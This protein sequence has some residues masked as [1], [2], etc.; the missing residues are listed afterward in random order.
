MHYCERLHNPLKHKFRRFLAI[1]RDSCKNITM[2]P[3]WE[4]APHEESEGAEILVST[5]GDSY[6]RT[7]SLD[8]F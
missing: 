7:H 3:T 4:D 5:P 6:Q 1:F 8:Q 2:T